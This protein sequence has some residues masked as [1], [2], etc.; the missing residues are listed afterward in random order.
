[1]LAQGQ[2]FVEIPADSPVL[3]F[4]RSLKPRI[5]IHQDIDTPRCAGRASSEEG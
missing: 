1:M 5:E 2:L 4:A 3:T